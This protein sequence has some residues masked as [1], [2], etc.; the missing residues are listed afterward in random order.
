MGVGHSHSPS[1]ARCLPASCAYHSQQ[2]AQFVIDIIRRCHGVGHFMAENLAVATAQPL[3]CLLERRFLCATLTRQIGV[4]AGLGIAHE[5]VLDRREERAAPL[6]DQLGLDTVQHTLQ[7]GEGPASFIEP[8]GRQLANLF[9]LVTRLGPAAVPRTNRRAAAALQRVRAAPLANDKVIQR[10][11][12]E[13]AEPP[14]LRPRRGE[15]VALDQV[16]E[17]R[18]SQIFGVGPPV[19]AASNAGLN[20]IPISPAKLFKGVLSA[21]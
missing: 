7:Q 17:K 18:L 1:G 8:F 13:S 16:L 14:A 10:H 20:G 4:G 12:H 9:P 5:P 15:G 21:R 6:G 3:D 2:V 11:A 19:A